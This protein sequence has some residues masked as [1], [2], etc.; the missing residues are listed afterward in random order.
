MAFEPFLTPEAIEQLKEAE[1]LASHSQKRTPQQIDAIYS[2]GQN[3]LVSASAG[4]GKTFVMVERILDKILRGISV[5][6]LFISTFTVKAATELRERLEKKLYTQLAQTTDHKLKAYLTDQL[7]SLSQADI[8]TMDAF[9]QKV[10]NQY[11]YRLG[12]SPQFRIMQDKAEQDILKHEIFSQLFTEFMTQEENQ[13]F[14]ALVKNFSANRKDA[15]AFRELV[16]TCYSFSQSTEDPEFWLQETFLRAAKSYKSFDDIPDQEIALLLSC[17]QN[18]ADQLRDLT[19]MEEY[20]QLTKA[21]KPAAKYVKHLKMIENLYEWSREF[22]RL[23]GKA[24]L[25]QLA[26]DITAMLPSGNHI[27]VAGKKYPVFKSLHQKLTGFRHLE[28]ILHYQAESLPILEVLQRFVIAFSEAYLIAKR[29][30]RTFEFSDIAHFAIRILE[31]NPDIRRA[32]Q[33]QY[34]EVMV[35][36]Y[37]DN[38]HMQE[39]LLTLL[40]NGHNRFMVGDIKQSIYRF[41]QADPQIF[42][43][44]FKD[45]QLHPEH[46]KLILLKENFRSQSEVLQ[47]SNAVF[48]HLMDESL[49]DILYDDQHRLVAGT[50]SQRIAYP[51]HRAQLFLYNTD[52]ND[53]TDATDNDG[54]SPSEVKIVAKEIIKLHND[55]GVA[56]EDITLLVSSRT[57]ND[58]IFQTF[59]Q[60]GIPLV[61]DGGQQNYLKSVEVMVML[62]TL[63]T[64]NNPR[65]DYALVALLRSPMFAFDEDE[66]ARLALQKRSK[67]SDCLYDKLQWALVGKGAHPELIHEDLMAKLSGFM[68][69]L[70]GWR[71]YAKMKSLYDLIWKIFNDRFYFDFVASQAK[72]EQ[73]Q[74]NLYA[75]AIRANQFEQSG[76]KGLSRFIGMIDKVLETQNDLADVEM[77]SPKQAVNLMTIHKSKGLE[78]KYVFIL[79]CDKRFSMID[80]HSPFILNRHHGIGI[81]YIADFKELL[82]EEKLTSVKVSIETLPYQMNKQELRLATLSEQMR[83][84]YV[85][86]TRAQK[87]IYLVGKASKEKSQEN[88]D[89]NCSGNQLP[90]SLREQLMSFQDWLIAIA[91]AFSKEDLHFDLHFVEDSDLSPEAIGQLKT[92]GF[93]RPDD[94]KD[95]RQSETITCALD[96]L[97]KVAELNASYQ[98]AINLPTVRT[99][100]QLKA[101]Y[102]PFLDTDGIDV[103]EKTYQ[104]TAHFDLPNFSKPKRVKAS[105][106]GSALHELMQK[107]PLSE[108]VTPITIEQ[109]LQKI[110]ADEAV[111]AAIDLQKVQSFFETTALGQAFQTYSKNLHREAPF[112]ILRTDTLSQEQYVVRGIIDA[113]LLFEDHIVLVDYKTDKYQ[114]LLDLKERYQNQLTLYAEALSQAYGIPVTEKYLVLMGGKDLHIVCA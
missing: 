81:K 88:F 31:E 74:A 103:I 21:G 65:N 97:E 2:S 79:N 89:D 55:K 58:A 56:F 59:N 6:R 64:I 35:D 102:D 32:Y 49:G 90:L 1:R 11:G 48:S 82:D 106:V 85:A 78:F 57:R 13:L 108:K 75:L 40:S 19:D 99:P 14:K 98:A 10:L 101:L 4:S 73:A 67:Y 28:T 66:L 52:R 94:L 86:M 54:I 80:T 39:R 3:I 107:I 114:N 12:I 68:E 93:L 43:Q 71:R 36:E 17:M 38:N 47:V 63:R 16:Y 70:A 91:F 27:I 26:Q 53:E 104:K 9:A 51:E 34:H 15:N 83:L 24:K 20:G 25:S 76:Y 46:G 23:Y 112:A 37:Q 111:K 96:M 60:Y 44:K 30:E 42:N 84:L 87:K 41:R 5:D 77:V 95:N 72:A 22:H 69:E 92:P 100:S 45:Y 8:G 105:Q 18:T 33:Q 62:D 61:A 109:T 113:Y 110:G 50:V 29:Q 7:Q